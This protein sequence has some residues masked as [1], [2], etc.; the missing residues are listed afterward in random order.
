MLGTANGIKKQGYDFLLLA[1]FLAFKRSL[2]TIHVPVLC[3]FF[4]AKRA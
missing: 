4:L 3:F 2:G 1:F